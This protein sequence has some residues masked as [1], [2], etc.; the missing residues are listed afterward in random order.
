MGADRGRG[1][2]PPGG[3]PPPPAPP[4]PPPPPD[5]GGIPVDIRWNRPFAEVCDLTKDPVYLSHDTLEVECTDYYAFRFH[6][7][8]NH[9]ELGDDETSYASWDRAMRTQVR[10][11]SQRDMARQIRRLDK[12]CCVQ[13]KRKTWT[14][15]LQGQLDKALQELIQNEHDPANYQWVLAQLDHQLVR[16][17]REVAIKRAAIPIDKKTKS[18]KKR[19]WER[20]SVTAYFKR[21]PRPERDIRD[22][23]QNRKNAQGTRYPSARQTYAPVVPQPGPPM[24]P[25]VQPGHPGVPGGPGVPNGPGGLG[26]GPP[27]GALMNNMPHGKPHLKAPGNKP[28]YGKAKPGI[29]VPHSRH[30]SSSSSSSSGYSDDG[31][32]AT[33]SS[34]TSWDESTFSSLSKRSRGRSRPRNNDWPR[35]DSRFWRLGSPRQHTRHGKHYMADSARFHPPHDLLVDA[36]PFAS[37]RPLAREMARIGDISYLAGR[38]DER[39][40]YRALEQPER[41]PRPGSLSRPHVR[42]VRG[43]KGRGPRALL[44]YPDDDP[45]DLDRR[46]LG[47]SWGRMEVPR[48]RPADHGRIGG[49]P[50]RG[51]EPRPRHN[52]SF[53][54]VGDRFEMHH[55]PTRHRAGSDEPPK[56][57]L[58]T[59]MAETTMT[60]IATA[61][62]MSS[63]HS[64]ARC[65]PAYTAH[66]ATIVFCIGT[67]PHSTRVTDSHGEL[68]GDVSMREVSSCVLKGF[69]STECSFLAVWLPLTSSGNYGIVEMGNASGW[70]LAL[71]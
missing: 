2:G 37:P 22:L 23:Y 50:A 55:A 43:R 36:S 7:F 18:Y 30:S 42:H 15:A 51:G 70:T 5:K 67:R 48:G 32:G 17:P 25:P 14:V 1:G 12:H 69:L 29:K 28:P 31:S 3:P 9:H 61:A 10:D 47:D 27:P 56:H 34:R 54:E 8:T 19:Y 59:F 60:A 41:E 65:G 52:N 68:R 38:R 6:E 53:S 20:I 13:E 4:G 11:L 62:S 63:I 46:A 26:G 49:S 24:K 58:Y 16:V 45:I 71:Y 40:R 57:A 33:S 21:I 66:I 35:E 64:D 39:D 44:P